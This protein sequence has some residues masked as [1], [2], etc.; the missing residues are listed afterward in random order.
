MAQITEVRPGVTLACDDEWFGSPWLEPI[1]VML[2]HGVAESAVAWRQWV[3]HIGID[4][5][6]VRPDMAG[7]GRSPVPDRY[8]WSPQEV[9][10]DYVRLADALGIGRFHLVGA[11]Y[12][13]SIAMQLTADFP[14]RVRSLAV[15]GAPARGHGLTA[16]FA[17]V[18]TLIREIGVAGWAER[19]QKSRLGPDAPAAQLDWWTHGLMGRTDERAALGATAAAADMNVESRLGDIRAETLVVTT[20]D[21]PLQPIAT[22]EAYQQAISHSQLKVLPGNCYHVAAVRPA[23]CAAVWKAF[24]AGIAH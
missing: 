18:P 9:A 11:K 3:P 5:R 24:A 4:Y 12:G 16:N 21:S 23:E 15:F 20:E 13:G 14:D 2:V 19:T 8:S 17:A 10:A 6:V 22:V 7:H 1:P